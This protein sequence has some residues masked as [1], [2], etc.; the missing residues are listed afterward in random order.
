MNDT[1]TDCAQIVAKNPTA[2]QDP[3]VE[4]AMPPT[5]A[6]PAE[7]SRPMTFCMH[8]PH[9]ADAHEHSRGAQCLV[10]Y[11]ALGDSAFLET[12]HPHGDPCLC[13]GYEPATQRMEAHV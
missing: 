2:Q 10:Y 13:P 4:P 5:F 1:E 12:S 3:G 11:G 6:Q 8:C 7:R 9:T